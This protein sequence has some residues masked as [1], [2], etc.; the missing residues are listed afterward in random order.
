MALRR[1]RIAVDMDE[2]IA[3]FRSG[4]LSAY[5]EAFGAGLTLAELGGRDLEDVVP[6]AHAEGAR[7]LVLEPGFF[8]RLPEVVGSRE[9][10][11]ALSGPYEVFV[12]TAAMEV[13]SSFAD[14]FDWLR[15][16]FPFVPPSHIVFCGDKGV[17]DVDYLIDDTARHFARFRGTP[18]LFDAPHNRAE[19]RYT[20]VRDWDE[21]RRML[22]PEAVP[23][24]FDGGQALAGEGRA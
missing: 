15:S 24:A 22:L 3:D 19:K 14:K 20:R 2:V 4:H 5:N 16:R 9:A 18:I 1:R 23:T 10:V 8:A 13:P 17:L 6:A 21:V 7:Q 11:L 12:A